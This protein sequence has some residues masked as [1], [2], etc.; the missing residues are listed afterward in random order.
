MRGD[1]ITL[2]GSDVYSVRMKLTTTFKRLC[3]FKITKYEHYKDNVI[4]NMFINPDFVKCVVDQ[5]R[6]VSLLLPSPCL[7]LLLGLFKELM[8]KVT[9]FQFVYNLLKAMWFNNRASFY[10]IGVHPD[11]Q[12]KGITAIIFNEMQKTLQ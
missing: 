1:I 2:R 11:F 8:G 4:L 3:P 6:I 12:N 9:F 10:L 5:K 7:H